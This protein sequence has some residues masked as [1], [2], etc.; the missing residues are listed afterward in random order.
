MA[1]TVTVCQNEVVRSC[2]FVVALV[3][4]R[5]GW[6]PQAERVVRA[7]EE[8]G[9]TGD[10]PDHGVTDLQLEFGAGAGPGAFAYFRQLDTPA[11]LPD[12]SANQDTRPLPANTP[13]AGGAKAALPYHPLSSVAARR[14]VDGSQSRSVSC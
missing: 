12:C 6:V 4:D 5:Y 8:S 9:L 2:P 11:D 3:G 7:I 13:G 1:L 14:P 10:F